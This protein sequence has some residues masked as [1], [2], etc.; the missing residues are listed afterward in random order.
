MNHPCPGEYPSIAATLQT[1]ENQIMAAERANKRYI[2][3]NCDVRF[4]QIKVN[5][6]NL[7]IGYWMA[8]TKIRFGPP[9]EITTITIL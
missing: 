1:A 6:Q 7:S 8:K 9:T 3:N 4:L 2:N 5:L